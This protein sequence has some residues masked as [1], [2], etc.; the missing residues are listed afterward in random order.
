MNALLLQNAKCKMQ[1]NT[2]KIQ[3]KEPQE[4]GYFLRFNRLDIYTLT[5]KMLPA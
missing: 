2:A 4:C 1:R 5:P 3:Y